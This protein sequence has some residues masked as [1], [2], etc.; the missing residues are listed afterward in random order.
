MVISIEILDIK[1]KLKGINKIKLALI[2]GMAGIMLIFLSDFIPQKE[3]TSETGV[4]NLESYTKNLEQK[5][6]KTISKISGIGKTE[7]M[8]TLEKGNENEY[9]Y[10]TK[11]ESEEKSDTE[12]E[13]SKKNTEKNYFTVNGDNGMQT[14][15]KAVKEPQIKG[16]LVVCEGGGSIQIQT[17]VTEAVS[18]VFSISTAKICVT[19]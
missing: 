14:V 8:I 19:N 16:I 13:S 7:V 18:K 5:L 15:L 9:L 6:E 2:A 4:Q 3:T 12:S 1:E 11:A 10:N 17:K